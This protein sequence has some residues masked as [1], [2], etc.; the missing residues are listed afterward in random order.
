[1]LNTAYADGLLSANTLS[2]RLDQLYGTLLLDPEPLIG[3]LTQRTSHRGL[4]ASLQDSIADRFRV[5]GSRRR[6]MVLAL[7][8][9]GGCDQLSVGRSRAS[10]VVLSDPEV[11]RRH[12][13]LRFRDGK[14]IL[15][16]LQ[17]RNGTTVNG[18][19]VGRCE[20]RP[21]DRLVIGSHEL[22]VD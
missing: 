16:D 15:E 18:V 3:D 10:D 9:T 22:E 20:L 1:M 6:W 13:Q 4:W 12:A 21:G 8:W 2:H 14:W 7:D 17:S 19:R 11:S 5:T